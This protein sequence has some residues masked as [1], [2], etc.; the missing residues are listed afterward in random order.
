MR[1]SSRTLIAVCLMLVMSLAGFVVARYAVQSDIDA[2]RDRGAEVAANVARIEHLWRQARSRF[3]AGG[4]FLFG[5]FCAADAMYAPVVTRFQT[6]SIHVAEDSRRYMDAVMD[7][8]AFQAWQ[9]AGLNESW[10][11]E[12]DE[13]DEPAIGPFR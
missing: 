12:H 3:G 8:P 6:Y 2:E 5:A 9:K 13:V 4:P 1:L 11:V 10:I 7:L